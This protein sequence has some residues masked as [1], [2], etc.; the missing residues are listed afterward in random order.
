LGR[1]KSRKVLPAIATFLSQGIKFYLLALITVKIGDRVKKLLEF[2]YKPIAIC[3][4]LCIIGILVFI[5]I[6]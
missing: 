5:K 4:A 6:V 3:L 2:N 1:E